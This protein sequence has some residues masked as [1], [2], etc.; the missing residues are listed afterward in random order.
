V[1]GAF[2]ERVLAEEGVALQQLLGAWRRGG[3]LRRARC[4]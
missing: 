2:M 1:Y 3:G 4:R